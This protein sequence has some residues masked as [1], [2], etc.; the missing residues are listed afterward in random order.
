MFRR[1]VFAPANV[2]LNSRT[3]TRFPF[4][5]DS[6]ELR[7]VF[8]FPWRDFFVRHLECELINWKLPIQVPNPV[9]PRLIRSF[10]PATISNYEFT[11]HGGIIGGK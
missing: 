10:L 9:M 6:K 7:P 2:E 11:S 4:L 3:W 1:N 5:Y 8:L